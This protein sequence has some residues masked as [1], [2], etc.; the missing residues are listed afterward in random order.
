MH[1]EFG[2]KPDV[3]IGDMDSVSDEALKRCDE[4]IVHAYPDERAPGLAR[5]KQMGLSAKK[6]VAP[7]SM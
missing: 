2:Y 7:G 5:I 4:I 3:V 1:M 6:F